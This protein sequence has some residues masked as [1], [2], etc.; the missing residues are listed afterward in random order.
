MVDAPIPNQANYQDAQSFN[1]D[2]DKIYT[3]FIQAIDKIRS[4]S[5][6]TSI[7]S[8]QV[9][10]A[11][12]N[13]STIKDVRSSFSQMITLDI[14]PQESRCHAFYR[15]IG[16]PVSDASK[17][18][19]NPGHDIIFDKSRKIDDDY[20]IGVLKNPIDKFRELSV[21]REN[22]TSGNLAIFSLSTSLDASTLS[23]SSGFKIR[24]FITPLNDTDGFNV[25]PS[26]QQNTVDYSSLVGIQPKKLT[27]YQDGLG[28]IPTKLPTTRTHLIRPFLVDPIIDLT[29][30][31]STKLIGIPFVPDKSYLK[32]KD[33]T[34][35]FVS[36]PLIEQVIRDRFS[37]TNSVDTTETADQSVLD[38]IKSIPSITD[39][40][41]I[42][43]A[44]T[45]F[46]LTDQTQ[47]VKFFNILRAMVKKLVQAQ[48][49]IQNAISSYYWLP[50]PASIGPEGGCTN[51]GVIL[52]SQID[53]TF[54]TS[55]DQA[56]IMA[57]IQ[58]IVSQ[59]STLTDNSTGT[60][61]VGGFAFD[62]FKTTFGPDTSNALGNNSD[63]NLQKLNSK[64]T[65]IL[66]KANAALRTVEIITGEFSGL[67][68]CD[69]IA[70]LAGLYL[71]PQN[72]LLGFLDDDAITRMN[73]AG[74]TGSASSL[75]TATS[76]FISVVQGFYNIMDS[77]YADL[78][79]NNGQTPA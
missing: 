76:S 17:K 64:R 46:K 29:I 13:V 32:V 2:I 4:Y 15:I 49:D 16:F 22:F 43:K 59:V 48:L 78:S 70:V 55:K 62:S 19:Y 24:P 42:T 63:D 23:L 20:K 26:A 52:S 3:D 7:T 50:I 34:D 79:Q 56:I 25:V 14:T 67:G 41:I 12:A 73:T 40:D 8:S 18:I 77:I 21:A 71:M 27:E 61:D 57:K 60:P 53:P 45:S 5:I 39:Q 30:N 10:N 35:G 72:D 11:I 6:T 74:L 33:G 75:A 69:I 65:S 54:V 66:N 44:T 68:L 36:R 9:K 38:Y 37:I 51:Q 1:I 58:L 31:D 28:N 47:F